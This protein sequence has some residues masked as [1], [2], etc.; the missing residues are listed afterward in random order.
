MIE[1][2]LGAGLFRVIT[3]PGVGDTDFEEF[4]DPV[5]VE[6]LCKRAFTPGM[7]VD[8]ENGEL[9]Y[10]TRGCGCP[11]ATEEGT[12]YL[13]SAKASGGV[14]GGAESLLQRRL[15]SEANRLLD[16]E[17]EGEVVSEHLAAT[18]QAAVLSVQ[19]DAR[20][21]SEED[22]LSLEPPP[23][24][25]AVLGPPSACSPAFISQLASQL[26]EN[27]QC[28]ALPVAGC[29]SLSS[30]ADQVLSSF[31]PFSPEGEKRKHLFVCPVLCDPPPFSTATYAAWCSD[32]A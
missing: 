10:T 12:D 21:T 9:W 1:D 11:G 14:D 2:D 30:G 5:R 13:D 3:L 29:E 27:M 32:V 22:R 15:A 17:V 31:V 23:E 25:Y 18:V 24:G 4:P 16:E 7:R 6:R 20:C 28:Q 19:Q 26:G 8:V